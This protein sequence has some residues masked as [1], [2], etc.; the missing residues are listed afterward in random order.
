MKK[1][2][3]WHHES[4]SKNV[5]YNFRKHVNTYHFKYDIKWKMLHQDLY[6][7]NLLIC[8][9]DS[10]QFNL[11]YN[12]H[13]TFDHTTN[14]VSSYIWI[15]TFV[16]LVVDITFRSLILLIFLH[17]IRAFSTE[18]HLSSWNHPEWFQGI[19]AIC[20]WLFFHPI[21]IC[22]IYYWWGELNHF[23]LG[24]DRLQG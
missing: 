18:V 3:S 23:C 13:S 19:V 24:K 8:P 14:N 1:Y 9:C 4:S 10:G 5:S 21:Q 7:N 6:H 22:F 17:C 16:C 20:K 15:S 11:M 12:M 2:K